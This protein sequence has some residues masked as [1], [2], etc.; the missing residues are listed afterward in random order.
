M[1]EFQQYVTEK[2]Q[3]LAML[4]RAGI[5]HGTRDD[6]HADPAYSTPR[7]AVQVEND[8]GDDLM[9]TEFAF[10]T[11]GRLVSVHCLKSEGG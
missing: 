1:K 9:I 7:T 2:E 5:G 4:K 6:S 3:L 10:D 11:D 8:D